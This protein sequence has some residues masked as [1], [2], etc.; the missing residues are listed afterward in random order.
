MNSSYISSAKSG[1]AKAWTAA[2]DSRSK[3]KDASDTN[4][5]FDELDSA[6]VAGIP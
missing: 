6:S 2:P 5:D 4:T 1:Y 3:I